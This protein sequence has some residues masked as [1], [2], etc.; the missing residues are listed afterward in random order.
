MPTID[1]QKLF[2]SL[3]ELNIVPEQVL[4]SAFEESKKTNVPLEKILLQKELVKD[5]E[6]GAIIAD[7]T[8]IPY[9]DVARMT[10]PADVINIIPQF[11]AKKQKTIAL[12]RDANGLKIATSNPKNQ[13]FF[14]LLAKKTGDKIS[15]VYATER[16]IE[17]AF[18]FYQK[19]I[20]K[21]F[22][23]L[24]LQSVEEAGKGLQNEAPISKIVDLLM[25]YAN[26]NHA[27]DIHIEPYEQDSLIRFRIDGV[28]HDVLRLP[29]N[30]HDQIITRIKILSKLRTD[31]HL[32]AQD[33]KIRAKLDSEELDV[34]VSIVPIVEG[35]K[36]VLRLL[37][38]HSRQFALGELGLPQTCIQKV[39]NGFSKPFG[40][41][42]ATGPTGS[43]KTTTIYA[44]LKILNT[45]EKNIATIEDPVEYDIEGI[46]QIQV[47]IKTD[48]T[49]VNGLRS[50]VRQDPDIIFV[51]EIRDKE[52]AEIAV[53]SAMTGHLVLSTLH[54]NDAATTLPRLIDMDIEPFLVATTVNI[55][56]AQR[57][58]RKI[59]EKCRV[60]KT[61]RPEELKKHIHEDMLK[62]HFA[63]Q[64]TK[65]DS[66]TTYYGK[67]CDVCHNTG[68]FDRI[69]IFEVL[70]VTNS[71]KNLITSKADASTIA[72]KAIEEGM[73]TM[74]DDG[75]EKVKSGITTFEEILRAT[76]T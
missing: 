49:F 70:E 61:I 22:D 47:N 51:G 55:I 23:T 19:G 11:V 30:L 56:I 62:K 10:I 36:A 52:T 46:N 21:E 33:G 54:T 59:C 31:E 53:N 48:I 26:N 8:K 12:S 34:R 25:E 3:K 75:I 73:E 1:D 71:I 16:A 76:K 40:M 66:I 37:S 42:L 63:S 4:D 17:S 15:V 65:K 58:I 74:L 43:G 7:I 68:Y 28:L 27:S 5:R 2:D 44:I 6:L 39:K 32:K 57:L 50:I 18:K 13:E 67:G 69:G 14:E 35:E 20:Q 60:S 72:K 9:V 24:L 41:V 38:S 45:R 64:K 29:K